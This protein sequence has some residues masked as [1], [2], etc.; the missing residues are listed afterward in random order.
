[1]FTPVVCVTFDSEWLFCIKVT[2]VEREIISAASE[3]A[4]KVVTMSYPHLC[5]KSVPAAAPESQDL[6]LV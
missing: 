6:F 5:E 3:L 1:M 2:K 4:T